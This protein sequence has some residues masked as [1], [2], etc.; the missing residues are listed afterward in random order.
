[1]TR[2]QSID[3]QDARQS[4][5]CDAHDARK[6][7]RHRTRDNH[8]PHERADSL[9]TQDARQSISPATHMTRAN[10]RGQ[11]AM[12]NRPIAC[13][14]HGTRTIDRSPA[15]TH[16]AISTCRSATHSELAGD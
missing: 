7:Y 14:A 6:A 11:S 12:D 13:Y 9:A 3:T 15:W 2:G 1:M 5:G 4:I 8:R 10:P 16:N